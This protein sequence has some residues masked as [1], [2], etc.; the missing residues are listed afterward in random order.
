MMF[1]VSEVRTAH[2]PDWLSVKDALQAQGVPKDNILAA[3]HAFE[4][5]EGG[6]NE[7]HLSGESF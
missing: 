7:C 1:R 6:D 4:C 3:L 2:F 5:A